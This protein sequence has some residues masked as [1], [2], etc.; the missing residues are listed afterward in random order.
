[1]TEQTNTP[2]QIKNFDAAWHDAFMRRCAQ[3]IIQL[4]KSNQKTVNTH[5]SQIREKLAQAKPKKTSMFPV[6]HLRKLAEKR[7]LLAAS[8]MIE[9]A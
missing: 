8:K 3:G 1:M 9:V 6:S 4:N 7:R 2:V 5:V